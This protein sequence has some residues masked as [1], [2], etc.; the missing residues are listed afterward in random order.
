MLQSQARLQKVTVEVYR[1]KS[2]D[3]AAQKVYLTLMDQPEASSSTSLGC[4]V[5]FPG[6][7]MQKEAILTGRSL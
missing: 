1:A 6:E 3:L 2:R 5:A 7:S 4:L